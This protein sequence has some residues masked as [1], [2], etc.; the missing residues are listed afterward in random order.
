MA[1]LVVHQDFGHYSFISS[2]AFSRQWLEKEGGG[3][4]GVNGGGDGQRVLL[5]GADVLLF[6]ASRAD[7]S[8][9]QEL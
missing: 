2:L 5:E 9:R 8:R 4:R 6:D 7:E 1:N 3:L